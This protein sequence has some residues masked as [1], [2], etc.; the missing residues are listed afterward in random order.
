MAGDANLT[1]ANIKAG[2]SI[3][4]VAGS[5]PEFSVPKLRENLSGGYVGSGDWILSSTPSLRT[6]V[7]RVSAG[8]RYI[9][10]MGAVVGNRF[11]TAF[12]TTDPGAGNAAVSG[13]QIGSEEVNPT[14]Y[15]VCKN[16]YVPAVDGYIAIFK[17]SDANG[18]GAQSHLLRLDQL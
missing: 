8:C 4:G 9:S 17:N 15:Q 16:S 14:P 5:L 7:S 10:C 11:R 3:F 2:V 12:F 1:A 18:T 6:D 13:T